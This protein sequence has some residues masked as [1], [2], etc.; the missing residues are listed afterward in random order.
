MAL[1]AG[2]H[3]V[4]GT[5]GRINDFMQ[6]WELSVQGVQKLV[7]DEADRMLDM[8]FEPQIRTIITCIPPRRQT[9]FFT[10][11]WPQSIQRLAREFLNEPYQVNIGNRDELVG[12]KDI[13]Q[14]LRLCE[15]KE[16]N[17]ILVQVLMEYGIVGQGRRPGAKGLIF[18]NTKRVCDSLSHGLTHFGVSAR[19]IHGDK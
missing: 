15:P 6:S 11:T 18:C 1:R 8:G 9:V 10:A 14:V 3:A 17:D 19:A 13:T 12:N 16:K 5:P 4:I 2:V 7:I